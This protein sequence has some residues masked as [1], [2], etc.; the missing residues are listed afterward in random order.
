MSRWLFACLCW[1]VPLTACAQFP[2]SGEILDRLRSGGVLLHLV[3]L[4]Q[5]SVQ[6]EIRATPEQVE[7]AR[8]LA[9]EQRMRLQGLAQLP[10]ADAASRL[11]EARDACDSGLNR[12]LT[13][14]QRARLQEI[15]LQQSGPL[16]GLTNPDVAAAVN[17]S[18]EQRMKLQSLQEST[19]QTFSRLAQPPSGLGRGKAILDA[20]RE[21]QT[22]K[23]Q[24]D[25][26]A[27][28]L[29][30]PEQQQRWGELQG[31]KFFME[32]QGGPGRGRLFNR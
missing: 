26:Q 10:Q 22:V 24:A 29:L 28:A 7:Q 27:L 19:I 8:K 14:Q 12:I 5:P 9:Q 6:R 30:T 4:D 32:S 18:S 3:M 17:L 16:I 13:S 25:A 15:G 23:Q 11:A 1:C 21:G 2:S 31:P 20:V